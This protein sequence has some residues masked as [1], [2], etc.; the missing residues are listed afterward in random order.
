MHMWSAQRLIV[1]AVVASALAGYARVAVLLFARESNGAGRAVW[2]LVRQ[3]AGAGLVIRLG[4]LALVFDSV[5]G[6]MFY[7]VVPGA[8]WII[9]AAQAWQTVAIW[10]L[11]NL[12]LSR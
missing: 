2:D 12:L 1:L 3:D 9:L 10:R 6:P 8:G 5:R 7:D 11:G 4:W